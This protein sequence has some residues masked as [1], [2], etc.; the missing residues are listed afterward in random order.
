MLRHYDE[1]LQIHLDDVDKMIDY[2]EK[3]RNKIKEIIKDCI[4]K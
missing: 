4:E 1:P 3:L 2:S